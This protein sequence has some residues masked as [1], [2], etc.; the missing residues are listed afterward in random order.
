MRPLDR[1]NLVIVLVVA[2]GAAAG[3]DRARA[4]G[5]TDARIT[6]ASVQPE[7]ATSSPRTVDAAG[8]VDNAGRTSSETSR[9]EMSGMRA[10]ETGAERPTGTP[11]SGFPLPIEP[12]PRGPESTERP[13]PRAGDTQGAAL[14]APTEDV[15]GRAAQALCDRE[16]SC[17]RVGRGKT[18]ASLAACTNGVRPNLREDFS[19]T[20]CAKGFDPTIVATCLSAIRLAACDVHIEGLGSVNECQPNEMCARR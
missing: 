19:G 6:S 10:S 7:G 17:D 11:G 9:T 13:R 5:P 3:C 20:S 1:T 15:L 8:F 4:R 16:A 14:G 2:M 12:R 18:W